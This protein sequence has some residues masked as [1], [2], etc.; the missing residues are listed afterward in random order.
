MAS[1]T[2]FF[3]LEQGMSNLDVQYVGH[4]YQAKLGVFKQKVCMLLMQ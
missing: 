2:L 4:V 1:Q 3:D